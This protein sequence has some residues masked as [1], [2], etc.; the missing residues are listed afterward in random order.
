MWE[1]PAVSISPNPSFLGWSELGDLVLQIFLF[2]IQLIW[3]SRIIFDPWHSRK[4]FGLIPCGSCR[5]RV[6]ATLQV[7]T[8]EWFLM[9]LHVDWE[10]L[11]MCMMYWVF[12]ELI[13]LSRLC[14]VFCYIDRRRSERVRWCA[15]GKRQVT[16]RPTRMRHESNQMTRLCSGAQRCNAIRVTWAKLV[17]CVPRLWTDCAAQMCVVS[18]CPVYMIY[19]NPLDRFPRSSQY[20]MTILQ[21]DARG[22][23]RLTKNQA[24]SRPDYLWLHVVKY[25]ESCST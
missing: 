12:L 25:V 17:V 22:G 14:C 23:E 6:S 8:P 15:R 18:G 19:R 20:W 1:Q 21:T 7:F 2:I 16:Q 3:I 5:A 10:S 4:L 11:E 24:T 9:A 13:M